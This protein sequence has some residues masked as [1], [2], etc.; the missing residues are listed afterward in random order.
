[1]YPFLYKLKNEYPFLYK[2]KND[3]YVVVIGSLEYAAIYKEGLYINK[4]CIGECF[5]IPE[6]GAVTSYH[7]FF[8]EISALKFIQEWF[9]TVVI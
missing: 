6:H 4:A 1:M 8:D 2:L 3:E 7:V 9:N 5:E